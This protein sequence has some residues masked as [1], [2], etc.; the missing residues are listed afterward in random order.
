MPEKLMSELWDYIAQQF[1]DTISRAAPEQLSYRLSPNENSVAEVA[2]RGLG[3]SYQ[4][5][6]ILSGATTLEEA[7]HLD[8]SALDLLQAARNTYA[9]GKF[10]D[11]MAA[12][13]DALLLRADET[14]ALVGAQLAELSP[15]QRTQRYSTWW[16]ATYT[17]DEIVARM[18]WWLSYCDGQMHLLMAHCERASTTRQMRRG[19]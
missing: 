6:A 13:S 18:M 12:E 3:T 10:P 8:P 5:S 11:S 1:R 14:M 15:A 4:W 19:T 2:W 17:G 16:D 9:P 7:I